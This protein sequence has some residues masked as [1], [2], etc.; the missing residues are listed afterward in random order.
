MSLSLPERNGTHPENHAG[1]GAVHQGL[2]EAFGS[3]A[4]SLGSSVWVEEALLPLQLLW[5]SHTLLIADDSQKEHSTCSGG[6]QGGHAIAAVRE[7][8]GKEAREPDGPVICIVLTGSAHSLG[9]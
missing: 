6:E 4:G 1:R 7:Q 2:P 9:K 3:T 8:E 5:L